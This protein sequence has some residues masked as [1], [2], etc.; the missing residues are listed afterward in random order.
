MINPNT[1]ILGKELA[2]KLIEK[3]F[4]NDIVSSFFIV[5]YNPRAHHH[6][7]EEEEQQENN[8][9][10]NINKKKRYHFRLIWDRYF[11][12]SRCIISDG[13]LEWTAC[14]YCT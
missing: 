3:Y 9:E 2:S 13:Q 8:E 10:E 5:A 4:T 14:R 12:T 6:R 7:Q 11:G 1:H